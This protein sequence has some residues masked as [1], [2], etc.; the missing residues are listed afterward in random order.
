MATSTLTQQDSASVTYSLSGTGSDKFAISS[1]GV[2]TTAAAMDYETTSSYSL[3]VTVTDGTNTDT[4]TINITVNNITINTLA[5]TLAN[6][7]AALAESTS[8]GTAVASSS[9]NNPDS[10]TVTYTLSG[11]GSS[12]FSVDSSGNVT[13]NGSL[14]F[15]TA[16]SYALTLTATAGSTSVTDT[17]TVNVGNVEELNSAVLRYSAAYN[18]ASRSGF[19]ATAT[20]GPS[21]SSLP[22]YY[23]EQIGKTNTTAITSVDDTSNNY[24]P[25]E[26]N[27]GT[28]LNWR[29][30]FP[31][32]KDGEGTYAFAPSSAVL[33]GKYYSPLGTAVTSSI[34]NSEFITA[35]RLETAEYWFM[36]TD[37]SAADISYNSTSG[38]VEVLLLG[39]WGTSSYLYD[40]ANPPTNGWA[41]LV[42]DLGWNL[43]YQH[44]WD[45]LNTVGYSNLS[46]YQ[47][48]IDQRQSLSG[49]YGSG[50]F[51][52]SDQAAFESWMGTSSSI[53]WL[54][55]HEA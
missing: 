36:T 29:Y 32:D 47:I 17:F 34:S 11:T 41:K 42:Y 4:E 54:K 53:L 30:Y 19:S 21:G 26:I 27:S 48:I 45:A 15:E 20:R 50:S 46:N 8:S 22:A 7:G 35:G 52:S 23:L 24:V 5:T 39:S 28:E 31:I 49:G 13:T 37:K 43:T 18:S 1:S 12:N 16:Q 33:D 6:S 51:N 10:E 38:S 25:V 3:T 14:D 40:S 9:I 2:I 55:L 44:G